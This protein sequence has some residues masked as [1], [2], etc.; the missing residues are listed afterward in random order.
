MTDEVRDTSQDY[1]DCIG[2]TDERYKPATL[3]EFLG[4]NDIP[5]T[6]E[7]AEKLHNV[8]GWREHWKGM[9][10]FESEKISNYKQIIV[11]FKTKEDYDA[12]AKLVGVKLTP[13]TKSI[14][15]PPKEKSQMTLLRWID[16]NDT[17][18][19]VNDGEE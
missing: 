13:K 2:K 9:P 6:V 19:G 3:S 18:I 11:S 4:I 5:E 16:E 17:E 1:D 12:F 7:E 14:F 8:L 10:E 15:Y